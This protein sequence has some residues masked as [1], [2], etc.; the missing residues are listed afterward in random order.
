[1]NDVAEISI[2]LGLALVFGL[3]RGPG[4]DGPLRDVRRAEPPVAYTKRSLVVRLTPTIVE[5]ES[6]RLPLAR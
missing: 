1:L 6:G 4:P 3:S 2:I 5:H